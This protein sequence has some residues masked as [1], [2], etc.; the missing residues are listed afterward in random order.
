[1]HLVATCN[2]N[3]IIFSAKSLEERL[4][5]LG[6]LQFMEYA[7]SSGLADVLDGTQ[8]GNFTVFAPNAEAFQSEYLVSHVSF[9]CSS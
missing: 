1:M 5:D 7:Q 3:V 4:S 9:L 8:P 2:N 6:L